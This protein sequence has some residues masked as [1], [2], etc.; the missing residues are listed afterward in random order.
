MIFTIFDRIA[1]TN[2]CQKVLYSL[3]ILFFEPDIVN[4]S[5]VKQSIVL[6]GFQ[7]FKIGRFRSSSVPS[8]SVLTIQSDPIQSP[9]FSPKLIQSQKF[10]PKTIQS[11]QF[12]PKRIHSQINSVPKIQSCRFSPIII[13]SHINSVPKIQSR[14]IQSQQI[15]LLQSAI[16]ISYSE[17]NTTNTP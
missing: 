2:T 10:S 7:Y 16:S 1:I 9:K 14:K 4:V 8:N 15:H 13:Q 12:S 11:S 3:I 17:E 6:G 5:E